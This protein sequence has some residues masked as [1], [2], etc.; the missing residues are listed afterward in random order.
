MAR[1][2]LVLVVT[3][4]LAGCGARSGLREDVDPTLLG[5]GPVEPLECRVDADCDGG[6]DRC[7]GVRCVEGACQAAR[8]VKCDD[9]DPCTADTCDPATGACRSTLLALDLDGDGVRGPLPGKKAGEPGSCGD[10]CDDGSPK[11]FPGNGELCDGVDNDCNG[12]VDDDAR[13]V[14]APG[15]VPLLVSDPALSLAGAGGLAFGDKS[16]GYIGAYSAQSVGGDTKVVVRE[17]SATGAPDGPPISVNETAGDAFGGPVV[18]TGDRYGIAWSDRR[19]GDYEIYFNTLSPEGHKTGPDVRVTMAPDFSIAPTLAWNGSTFHLAWQDRRSGTFKLY[20]RELALDGTLLGDEV[21]LVSAGE[22]EVP[23][24]AGSS[25]GLG[26]VDR[27]GDSQDSAIEFRRLDAGFKQVGQTLLLDDGGRKE[28][29][30]LTKNGERFVA[31]WV[32]KDPHRVFGAVIGPSGVVEVPARLLSPPDAQSR[33]PIALPLGD[34][35]VLL[36]SRQ[37]PDGYDLF[38]QPLTGA[39]EPDGAEAQLTA[40]PGDDFAAAL[41][42][43][44]A[45]DVGVLFNGRIGGDDGLKTAVFF[46]RL[47]CAAGK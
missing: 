22:A 16:T 40:S 19:D 8:P 24:L 29:P 34:R 30:Y 2:R 42:F 41:S 35:L 46:S 21:T 10:D 47:V 9:G 1:A 36:Y 32:R 4:S 26:L 39:L 28:T 3:L 11:A 33:G 12:V 23:W 37:G 20:A 17:L 45:G 44:P 15:E 18:W 5:A 38:S 13:F 14:P 6:E 7:L 31:L 25:S 43:G 27:I